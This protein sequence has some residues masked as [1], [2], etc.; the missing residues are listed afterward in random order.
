METRFLRTRGSVL[1]L[2]A[3]TNSKCVKTQT[4]LKVSCFC[5]FHV[6]AWDFFLI[7]R[8]IFSRWCF[9]DLGSFHHWVPLGQGSPTCRI[10]C[11]IIWSRANV[12]VTETK[13]AV[14]VTRLT[15]PKSFPH[16]TGLRQNCLSRNWSLVPKRLG[17][18]GLGHSAS[19]K[20]D[21]DLKIIYHCYSPSA[22]KD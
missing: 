17:T 21:A 22:G 20:E 2:A 12:I 11:L 8:P 14:N 18:N 10:S 4:H 15:H 13:C 7:N 1:L 5:F 19:R 9:R 3:L 16:A 6:E